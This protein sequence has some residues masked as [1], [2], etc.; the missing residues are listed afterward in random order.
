M[1]REEIL[2]SESYWTSAIQLDLFN[3]I[4]SFMEKN[5]LNKK[6]LAE[7][8]N[9]SK[10]YISQVL[11][12]EFD[13]KISKM[14]KLA[15]ACDSVPLMFFVD[16]DTFIKNDSEEKTYEIVSRSRRKNYHEDLP[17]SSK[18]YSIACLTSK[19]FSTE[20]KRVEKSSTS[21]YVVKNELQNST[22]KTG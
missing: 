15:L 1:E 19:L 5:N 10:G 8:L 7:H 18:D 14:V 9:F 4:E 20:Y 21:M 16:K 2:N 11:N 12:G 6:Q 17:A 3:S 22:K 13:H